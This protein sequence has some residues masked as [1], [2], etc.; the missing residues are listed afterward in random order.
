MYGLTNF[1]LPY[2]VYKRYVNH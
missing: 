2:A 1:K